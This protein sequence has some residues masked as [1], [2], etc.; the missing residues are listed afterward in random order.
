MNS[1]MKTQNCVV[2]GGDE[3]IHLCEKGGMQYVM[4]EGCAHVYVKTI[5]MSHAVSNRGMEEKSH[6]VSET[7]QEWDYSQLKEKFVYSP[8]FNQIETFIRAG[9]LLDVGC[10]NGSFVHAAMRRGWD[11]CGIEV[12]SESVRVAKRH[13]ILVYKGR[14]EDQT[15]PSDHFS[16]VTMWQVLEHLPDPRKVIHE[17]VRILRPGGILALST[18]NIRSIGWK[19]L[20]ADWPAIEPAVHFNLFHYKGLERFTRDSGLKKRLIEALD[21]EPATMKQLMCRLQTRKA[22]KFVNTTA[23]LA[24]SLSPRKM[25]ALFKLRCL[26]NIPLKTLRIGENLYGYFEKP[27]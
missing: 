25:K 26:I 2:C 9:Y 7:K 1:E 22:Q 19:L 23:A 20:R 6:H 8:R 24:A 16:A 4:C 15:F 5:G 13:G 17:T 18:P 14:L 12:R 27:H 3:S 10:S 21:L 11:A